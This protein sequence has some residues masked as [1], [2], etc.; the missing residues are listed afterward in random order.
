MAKATET[1]QGTLT[2]ARP[3]TSL[4]LECSFAPKQ[5]TTVTATLQLQAAG[6]KVPATYTLRY[7]YAKK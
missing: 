7:I 5:Y 4:L 3:K 1:R 2:E 6:E